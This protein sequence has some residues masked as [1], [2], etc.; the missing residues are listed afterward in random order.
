MDARSARR[1]ASASARNARR[2][3]LIHA[4]CVNDFGSAG[5]YCVPVAVVWL[6]LP[7]D[8]DDAAAAATA[9]VAAAAAIMPSVIPPT[10]AAE[11]AIAP[12]P[13]LP[14]DAGPAVVCAAALAAVDTATT[15]AKTSLF[16]F[17]TLLRE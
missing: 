14:D 16:I 9:T 8:D 1:S 5:F 10:D 6:R 7:D 15:R 17:S 3:C 4:A 11:A 13:P 2:S 12:A